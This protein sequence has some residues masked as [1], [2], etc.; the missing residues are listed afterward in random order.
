MDIKLKG[1]LDGIDAAKKIKKKRDVAIVFVSGNSDLL[2]S[3]RLKKIKP[4]GIMHKPI[5]GYE[6][7]DVLNN[8]FQ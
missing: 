3:D 2:K 6:L 1:H 5:I 8:V 7:T 4:A